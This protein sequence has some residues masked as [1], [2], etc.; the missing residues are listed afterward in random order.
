MLRGSGR[1]RR[2]GMQSSSVAD[3]QLD[4]Y[5]L[6]VCGL[7]DSLPDRVRRSVAHRPAHDPCAIV[8]RIV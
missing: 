1:V 6:Q 8:G 4:E 5:S 3:P 7:G 2:F